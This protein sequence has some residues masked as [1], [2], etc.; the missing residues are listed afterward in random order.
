[1]RGSIRMFVGL[2]LTMGAAGGIDNATDSQL[3][4]CIA[5]AIVGLAIMSSG[6]ASMNKNNA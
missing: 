6:I 5:I 1:M 4:P 3:L 2:V